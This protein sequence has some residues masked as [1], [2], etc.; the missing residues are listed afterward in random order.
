MVKI[1]E[2]SL[3]RTTLRGRRER[4]R[5]PVSDPVGVWQQVADLWDQVIALT[6]ID[7]TTSLRY[8]VLLT[9]GF[10]GVEYFA[11]VPDAPH[12]DTSLDELPFDGGLYLFGEHVGGA[13][14]LKDSAHWFYESYLPTAPYDLREGP[15]VHLLD[16]R[17][18]DGDEACV[19]SFGSP[20]ER[21]NT[22]R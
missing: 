2:Y 5:N 3:S 20:V 13:Q 16:A 11:G 17:F 6:A 1:E 18:R 7:P 10:G 15:M 21:H 4:L 12:L 19:L 8:G 22:E 9:D 14:T